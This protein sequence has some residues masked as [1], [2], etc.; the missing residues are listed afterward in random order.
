LQACEQR[1]QTATAKG[2]GSIRLTGVVAE[3]YLVNALRKHFRHGAYLAAPK[4]FLRDI[5]EESN[6]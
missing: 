6:S 2:D 4:C 5:F 3:L 1:Q